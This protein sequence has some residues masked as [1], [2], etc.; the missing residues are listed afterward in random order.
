VL[1]AISTFL[2]FVMVLDSASLEF[3]NK[4][5]CQCQN[6]ESKPCYFFKKVIIIVIYC[7]PFSYIRDKS[8]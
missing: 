5:E 8:S 1:I 4:S 6:P 3:S 2:R 7:M